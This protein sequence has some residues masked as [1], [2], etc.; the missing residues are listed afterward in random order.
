MNDLNEAIKKQQDNVINE[1][2]EPDFDR[3]GF[4]QRSRKRV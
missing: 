2:E 4:P 1:A 3:G